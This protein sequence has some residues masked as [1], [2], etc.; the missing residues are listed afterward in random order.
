MG[1][2][3]RREHEALLAEAKAKGWEVRRP[4]GRGYPKIKCPCGELFETVHYTPS[5]PNYWKYKRAYLS[6]HEC[7]NV[8][9]K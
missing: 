9:A 6:R 4:M 8:E 5:G 3:N 1:G 7:W 2:S